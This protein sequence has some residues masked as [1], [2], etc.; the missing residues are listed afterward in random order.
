VIGVKF[1][2]P[3]PNIPYYCVKRTPYHS[4]TALLQPC[5]LSLVFTLQYTQCVVCDTP[6]NLAFW[7]SSY[8]R[9]GRYW[10]APN[11]V[12]EK[13]PGDNPDGF[14]QRFGLAKWSGSP[15]SSGKSRQPHLH[16]LWASIVGWMEITTVRP[17]EAAK[18]N[19][20]KVR[21]AISRWS[22]VL[23]VLLE[24]S[25]P[26]CNTPAVWSKLSWRTCLC[27]SCGNGLS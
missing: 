15:T 19:C 5:C 26:P 25:V 24:Q 20:G 22:V 17:C 6:C 4:R 2:P 10:D 12:L 18:Q 8:R 7:L 11:F 9:Q 27:G 1:S 16:L 23:E 14:H 13:T 21:R 3:K